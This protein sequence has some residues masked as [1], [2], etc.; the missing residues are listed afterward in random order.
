VDSYLDNLIDKDIYLKKKEGLIKQK[1]ELHQKKS[2]FAKRGTSWIEPIP[3]RQN[4]IV[5]LVGGLPNY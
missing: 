4:R 1:T 3:P 5:R 2:D